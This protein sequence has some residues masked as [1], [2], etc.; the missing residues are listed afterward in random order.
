MKRH[1]TQRKEKAASTRCYSNFWLHHTPVKH[2]EI[3]KDPKRNADKDYKKK[4]LL[5]ANTVICMR[6][7]DLGAF[8]YDRIWNEIH[9]KS[10]NQNL[11]VL[12]WRS[13]TNFLRLSRRVLHVY[14]VH[15]C[16]FFW[17]TVHCCLLCLFCF[18][19]RLRLHLLS[20]MSF[21]PNKSK[22]MFRG[23]LGKHFCKTLAVLMNHSYQFERLKKR[24]MTQQTMFKLWNV[25]LHVLWIWWID[26]SCC[27]KPIN[28]QGS[29]YTIKT[30]VKHKN[31]H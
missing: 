22:E 16:F 6:G 12:S 30:Q 10:D 7:C 14:P 25:S 2:P 19:W 31:I 17:E 28:K 26:F 20:V 13:S 11:L 23:L 27:A 3:N 24:K 18:L 5:H 1:L 15:C 8:D 21:H 4:T 9:C 29:K